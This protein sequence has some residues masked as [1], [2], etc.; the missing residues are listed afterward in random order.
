MDDLNALNIA[1]RYLLRGYIDRVSRFERDVLTAATS[2][3]RF[4][5]PP[6]VAAVAA[7]VMDEPGADRGLNVADLMIDEA[8]DGRSFM[9]VV[10]L[11]GGDARALVVRKP[12]PMLEA[13]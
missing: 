13:S 5:L 7:A 1:R 4:G 2:G 6:D 9:V 8:E 12:A 11:K 10:E 3:E